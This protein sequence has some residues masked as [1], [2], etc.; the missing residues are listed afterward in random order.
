MVAKLLHDGFEEG[1]NLD[2]G[3]VRITVL[4]SPESDLYELR[5]SV[6]IYAVETITHQEIADAAG[7]PGGITNLVIKK[8]ELTRAR[9]LQE[10]R[11]YAD[12]HLL[13]R[14]TR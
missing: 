14:L 9:L 12:E 1:V 2:E 13:P 5:A 8:G 4:R 11:N 6:T 10:M 3:T 7:D